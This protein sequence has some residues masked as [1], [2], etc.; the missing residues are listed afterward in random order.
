MKI[1]QAW[2]FWLHGLRVNTIRSIVLFQKLVNP[3]KFTRFSQVLRC[4]N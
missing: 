4:I 1:D 3:E 2:I